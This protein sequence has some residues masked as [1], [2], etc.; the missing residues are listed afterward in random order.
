MPPP[1]PI[2]VPALSPRLP[3][4]PPPDSSNSYHPTALSMNPDASP[5]NGVNTLRMAENDIQ[6]T[7]RF[8]REFLVM[9]LIPW[10]EKCVVEW[11]EHV[12]FLHIGMHMHHPYTSVQFSSTRRLPSRLFS[13]TRR[14]FGSSSPSPAPTHSPSSSVVSLPSRAAYNTVMTASSSQASAPP[15]QQRRLAEFATMLG[16]FKLAVAVWEALRKE[17]KGGSVRHVFYILSQLTCH[18]RIFFLYYCLLHLH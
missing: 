11:N 3:P 18:N 10:M 12:S 16:D 14:L 15:L 7:A 5:S 13:S 2:P 8:A 4:P 17:S 1:P 6:Q 9:S